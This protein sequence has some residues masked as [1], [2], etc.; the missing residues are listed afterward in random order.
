[1]LALTVRT[2]YM[3]NEDWQVIC[4]RGRALRE[5]EGTLTGRAAGRD[6]SPA[7]DPTA[8]MKAIGTGHVGATSPPNGLP[9]RRRLLW[10][11]SVTN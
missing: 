3:P 9:D 8:A 10:S 7:L 4:R 5:A 2:S 11:T 6:T 1:V